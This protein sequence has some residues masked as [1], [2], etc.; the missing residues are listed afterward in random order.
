MRVSISPGNSKLGGV[1]SVSLPPGISC[2][3]GVSCL[4]SCYARK[5][6]YERFRTVRQAWD[7]NWN[8][9]QA[10]K[11]EYFNQIC[12]FLKRKKPTFFRW[13]VGGDITNQEYFD[14]MLLTAVITP[15]TK[16]LAYT[17]NGEIVLWNRMPENFTLRRS[18]WGEWVELPNDSSLVALVV[19]RGLGSQTPWHVCPGSCTDCGHRCWSGNVPTVVFEKH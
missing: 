14:M 1:P 12:Q 3:A 5:H 19:D 4:K 15:Y 8:I 16:H 13:H 17:A 10:D 6:C 7:N 18:V 11:S 2:P 9:L